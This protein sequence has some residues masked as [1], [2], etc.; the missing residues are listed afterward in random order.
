MIC[1]ISG[2]NEVVK[3][4]L[5]EILPLAWEIIPLEFVEK[6]WKTMP[7]RVAAVLEVRRRYTKY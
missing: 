3:R 4:K 5:A 1:D 7:N 2:E 6:L